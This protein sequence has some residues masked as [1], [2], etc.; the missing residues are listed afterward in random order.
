MGKY[1]LYSALHYVV[2]IIVAWYTNLRPRTH[3]LAGANVFSTKI[4]I[5]KWNVMP[6]ESKR[7]GESSKCM[8]EKRAYIAI[9]VAQ[10]VANVKLTGACIHCLREDNEPPQ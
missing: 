1:T 7:T 4:T 2:I 3:T 9:T 10:T 5:T 6:S 8:G